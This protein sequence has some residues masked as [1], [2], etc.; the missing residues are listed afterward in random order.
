MNRALRH[1]GPDDEGVFV[2]G[3]FALGATR[4]SIIDVEGGHQPLANEDGSVVAV[5]NGEIYNHPVLQEQLRSRGHVLR[6]GCD[7]EVLVHL[8]E[9]YGDD[10]VHA[11]DGMFAFAIWDTRRRRLLLARDR[12][13]EKPLFY[14]EAAGVLSFASELTALAP[15]ARPD[16]AAMDAFF[17]LGYVPG[18]RTMLEGV[19]QL[20]PG[21][22]LAFEDQAA[23]V[24]AYWRPP[25]LEASLP[26]DDPELVPEVER[27]LADS[28]RSRMIAD[29]PLGV[30]LSG[31]LDSTL[32]TSFAA[33]AST[34]PV[35]T[36]TVGYDVGGVSEAAA[37]R[38][39]AAA[40]GTEHHELLLRAEA[41]EPLAHELFTR[42]D[43]P[44]ADQALLAT[45]AVSKFARERVTV[46]VG[47]EGADEL[48]GG[49]PRYRWL[50]RAD[51][52][53]RHVPSGAGRAAAR[54]LRRLPLAGRAQRLANVVE[55]GSSLDRHLEWVTDGRAALR[56][57]FYG[58]KLTAAFTPKTL[59]PRFALG[60]DTARAFML[61][62][63][64]LWL[65]DDVLAK[66]DRAS[67]LASLE[68][69]TPFLHP[70]LAELAAAVPT[71]RHLG[72]GGK[73]LLRAVLAR[74]LGK[75]ASPRSKV[76]FRVPAA[77][78][79]RG[80]LVPTVREQ[81]AGGRLY[82]DGYVRADR[83]RAALEE[84][85]AGVRD[86]SSVLWPLMVLCFWLDRLGG[87]GPV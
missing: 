66:A 46:A 27:L 12:F 70:A 71:A 37:A 24:R 28:V 60:G 67:M 65:P 54:G 34:H 11:L 48:F 6:S 22:L 21:H 51:R 59:A 44:V 15:A 23:T 8:Y 79:L 75:V 16:P 29:V 45:Y 26:A 33:E 14:R 42:L 2:D 20:E 73:A 1:R 76:A 78:W 50:D 7:T 3:E 53:S 9:D 86:W 69:R 63:Q 81:I 17:V 72:G 5:L 85:V 41:V 82:A 19:R 58:D 36:F 87:A 83:V 56:G 49:Y 68:V 25:M 10:L 30:F 80:P 32:V 74:R 77:E 55:P 18:P 84:H 57:R 35:Q 43:Q 62:D 4:L 47:G 38:A 64:L 13:G 52:L 31:G 39:V 61:A 40:L